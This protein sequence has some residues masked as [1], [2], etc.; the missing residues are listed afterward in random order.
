MA[1]VILHE[2]SHFAK[3]ILLFACGACAVLAWAT[4]VG[5]FDQATGTLTYDVSAATAETQAFSAYGD[6]SKVV[7]KGVGALTIQPDNTDFSGTIDIKEGVFAAGNKTSTSATRVLGTAV[8]TVSKGAQFKSVQKSTYSSPYFADCTIYAEGD[9]PDGSGAIYL[10][11]PTSDWGDGVIPDTVMTGPMTL[12]G[13]QRCG[14]QSLDMG[15][16]A[17]TNKVDGDIEFR[18][19]S[20][21]RNPGTFVHLK[22]RTIQFLRASGLGSGGTLVMA[23]KGAIINLY[24]CTGTMDWTLKVK[25]DASINI[26]SGS[27]SKVATQNRWKGPVEID[28]GTTLSVKLAA[29][30]EMPMSFLSEISGKGK[31]KLVKYSS[32][33]NAN[34][35]FMHENSYSG[36]T[37]IESGNILHATVDNSIPRAGG[38]TATGGQV[39]LYLG[40]ADGWTAEHAHELYDAAAPNS[41]SETLSFHT[42]SDATFEDG[43]AFTAST[44]RVVHRGPGTLVSSGGIKR[45]NELAN[46]DGTWKVTGGHENFVR[47]FDALGGDLVFE[48]A[49]FVCLSNGWMA[50]GTTLTDNTAHQPRMTF[51]GNT[52][53]GCPPRS[54]N[55]DYDIMIVGRSAGKRGLVEIEDGAVITNRFHLGYSAGTIGSVCQRGGS[56]F[57]DSSNSGREAYWGYSGY[58]HYQVKG[59]ELLMGNAVMFGRTKTGTGVFSVDGGNSVTRGTITVGGG[60]TGVVHMTSGKFAM[61][62]G[63]P[64]GLNGL[65]WCESGNIAGQAIFTMAGRLAEAVVGDS[66]Q[67]C[68]R[69]NGA[70]A[71]LNLNA[72]VFQAKSILRWNLWSGS[73]S[74]HYGK[75]PKQQGLAYV[76]FNGGTFRCGA[77]G[78]VFLTADKKNV[79]RITVY[80]HGAVFD[81]NGKDASVDLPI[82]KPEGWGVKAIRI[83]AA[84]AKAGYLGPQVVMLKGGDANAV[85]ATAITDYDPSS[86]TVS[87]VEVMSQGC[88]YK[89]GDTVRAY[90]PDNAYAK[91]SELEVEMGEL[92]GGGLVKTG[93]GTLT[94]GAVNTYTGTTVVSNGTL[95]AAVAGAI[96]SKDITI[97][98]GAG[99]LDVTDIGLPAGTTVTVD[100]SMLK[101]NPTTSADRHFT[102]VKGLTTQPT[103]LGLETLPDSLW[104]VSFTNGKLVANYEI[105]MKIIVK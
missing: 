10:S 66:V 36:G 21:V 13:V 12:G 71:F 43:V 49:G 62:A 60:G 77:D 54:G 3:S 20:T 103:L 61:P 19:P 97:V 28:E 51:R 85:T 25:E 91:S 44:V 72:G 26:G 82:E 35:Y 22:S 63:S 100:G 86:Q 73:P 34:V 33:Y 92:V 57:V 83:P 95:V 48:D 80:E 101:A 56:V 78:A 76:N 45:F 69:T 15:G 64:L 98:A 104:R 90:L 42:P 18:Y 99:T 9:G 68:Q 87:S 5:S 31:V 47:S 74:Q 70:A 88:G 7:K 6:V 96:P 37:S 75:D 46:Y 27:M 59:G 17:L 23:C 52:A 29:S 65:Q 84:V 40:T 105:G 24:E 41:T 102:L 79:N 53:L 39:L 89:A 55:T 50:V 8:I 32:T 2:K 81:T 30:S 67:L 1:N 4:P 11:G 14:F 38:C 58:G 94:L 16:F 93:E